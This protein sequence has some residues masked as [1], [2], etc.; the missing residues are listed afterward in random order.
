MKTLNAK[1][2]CYHLKRLPPCY[3]HCKNNDTY[4]SGRIRCSPSNVFQLKKSVQLPIFYCR[5]NASLEDVTVVYSS[6]GCLCRLVA[7]LAFTVAMHTHLGVAVSTAICAYKDRVACRPQLF[8][9]SP[10][11]S[12][13]GKLTDP[14]LSH[15]QSSMHSTSPLASLLGKRLPGDGSND[16]NSF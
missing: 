3:T 1:H 13:V 6:S 14:L 16:V 7:C 4:R 5:Y 10:C 9:I 8:A 15:T 11:A 2:Q 12:V